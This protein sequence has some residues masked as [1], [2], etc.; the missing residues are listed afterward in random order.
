M[1]NIKIAAMTL[2]LASSTTFATETEVT[3][4]DKEAKPNGLTALSLNQ[5]ANHTTYRLSCLVH[6]DRFSGKGHSDLRFITDGNIKVIF[7]RID[8]STNGGNA[9]IQFPLNSMIVNGVT[10]ENSI[11]VQN[12]DKYDTIFIDHCVATPA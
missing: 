12:L 2:L 8:T 1:R 11:T 3:L 5:L 9:T 6:S 10:S 4:N 7:N